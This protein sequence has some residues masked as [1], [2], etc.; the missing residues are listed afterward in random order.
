[1]KVTHGLNRW[2]GADAVITGATI[3]C[4]ID[5]INALTYANV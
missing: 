2:H 3:V 5:P 1:M 4:S